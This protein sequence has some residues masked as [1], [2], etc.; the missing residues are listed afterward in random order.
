MEARLRTIG[1]LTVLAI[2]SVVSGFGGAVIGFDRGV[3]FAT[4]VALEAVGT[5]LYYRRLMHEALEISEEARPI[6]EAHDAAL[7]HEIRRLAPHL[8][9]SP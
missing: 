2:A 9:E 3:D 6:L 7:L 5:S 1:L 8:L 4:D